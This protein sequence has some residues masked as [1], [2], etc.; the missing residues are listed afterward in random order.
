M[1]FLKG[2]FLKRGICKREI[3]K[4]GDVSKGVIFHDWGMSIEMDFFKWS[5]LK[6]L[7]RELFKKRRFVSKGFLTTG[8]FQREICFKGDLKKEILPR[9]T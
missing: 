8:I 2:G 9:R 7:S 5:F 6:L 3:C 4:K 1:G